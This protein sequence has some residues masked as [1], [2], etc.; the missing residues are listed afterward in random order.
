MQNEPPRGFRLPRWALVGATIATAVVGTLAFAVFGVHTLF[1]D[2]EVDEAVP[3]F[4]SGAAPSGLPSDVMTVEEVDEMQ[5]VMTQEGTPVE[6]P[7]EEDMPMEGTPEIVVDVSGTFVDR[8]HPAEGTA[9]VL[10]DGSGQR[11]LRFEG[12]ATDNG[13]DRTSTSPPPR[14]MH[15]PASSTT[16][17]STSAISRATS[18]PRTTRSPPMSTCRGIARW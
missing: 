18:A 15:R 1:V 11:F 17:S 6:E 9:E 13:P 2:A 4:A 8:S 5:A 7:V 12:F 10:G 16:T 3:V 14:P